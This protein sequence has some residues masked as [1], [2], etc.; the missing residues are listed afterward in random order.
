M[1][2]FRHTENISFR[3]AENKPVAPPKIKM[4]RKAL[5]VVCGRTTRN[6]V[7][8]LVKL[9]SCSQSPVSFGNLAIRSRLATTPLNPGASMTT[10]TPHV[11]GRGLRITVTILALL[12]AAMVALFFITTGK[13]A[14]GAAELSDGTVTAHE[15]SD[16]LAAGAED[17]ATGADTLAS[18]SQDLADGAE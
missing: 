9:S 2:I 6:Q 10:S 14:A 18:G 12:L 17:L 11:H 15:G 13:I 4:I 8:V 7:P 16:A 3:Y 5:S 1:E